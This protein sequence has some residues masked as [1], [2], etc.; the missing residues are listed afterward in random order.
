MCTV[1]ATVGEGEYYRTFRY[2]PVFDVASSWNASLVWYA[3]LFALDPVTILCVILL[4]YVLLGIIDVA[5][6]CYTLRWVLVKMLLRNRSCIP[7]SSCSSSP[8]SSWKKKVSA[9]NTSE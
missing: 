9:L 7:L 5:Q 2:G 3:H 6:F 8:S 1:V 4:V